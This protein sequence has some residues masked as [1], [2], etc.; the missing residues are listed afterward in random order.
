MN[1]KIIGDC[2]GET[3]PSE[4]LFISK[5][6][7]RIGDYVVLEYG[8]KKIIGMIENLLRGSP[9]IT[10]SIRNPETVEKI[11]SIEGGNDEYI[12]GT[13][14]LLGD[15][16]NMEIPRTPPPPGTK[17][18]E[19]D[20]EYLKKVFG[21]GGLILGNLISNQN[22][23]VTIDINKMITR[24]LAILAITGAG[25]SNTVGVIIDKL[26]KY[27]GCVLIF[28]MHSEYSRSQFEGKTNLII[29]KISPLYMSPNEFNGLLKIGEEKSH[30]QERHARN[31]YK[32]ALEKSKQG[33]D[34][35]ESMFKE[36]NERKEENKNEK[37]AITSIENKLEDFLER[38]GDIVDINAKDIADQLKI[39]HVNIIDF[40]QIDET[41]SDAI[42]SHILRRT[43][44]KRKEYTKT[45]DGIPYPIF[46]ILEEAHI[47][48]PTSRSTKSKYWISRVARE[49]RK[50][51]VG[52]CFV[53]QRPK[54][55]DPEALSQ[56]NNMIILRLVEPNDQRHVQQSSERLSDELLRLLP[57]LNIG[58]AVVLGLMTKI[59]TLVKIDKFKGKLVGG[60]PDVIKIWKEYS[61]KQ[62]KDL[63]QNRKNVDDMYTW[64]A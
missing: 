20:E 22:V 13:V 35:F 37:V 43:L 14:R 7:P 17:I 30:V 55:L 58:E 16:E 25:K 15:I 10:N 62:E 50:F 39:G 60:D 32:A 21:N 9:Y 5:E 54:S 3:S 40:G 48:A 6:I 31:A 34:F 42:A 2:I 63:E 44:M 59:P 12:R 11:L 38:Y 33:G 47:L 61:E 45:G 23:P 49:G 26:L 27:N 36:L 1:N 8:G 19:A 51:G 64:K 29:P 41:I 18:K 46:I 52:L 4:V 24:H 28:D 53:S 56:A 57:S